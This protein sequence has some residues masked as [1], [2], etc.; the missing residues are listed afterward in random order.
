MP[1][2]EKGGVTIQYRVHL[3]SCHRAALMV[4]GSGTAHSAVLRVCPDTLGRIT[5]FSKH[6]PN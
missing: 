4:F 3:L 6:E 1:F 5:K 2:L